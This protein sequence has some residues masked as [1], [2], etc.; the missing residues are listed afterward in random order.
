MLN[1]INHLIVSM[2]RLNLALL[3]S[4]NVTIA[5]HHGFLNQK[6]D[7]CSKAWLPAR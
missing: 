2:L 4:N 6:Q 5:N 3:E 7:L 1:G